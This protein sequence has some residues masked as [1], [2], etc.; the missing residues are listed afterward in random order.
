MRIATAVAR[1]RAASAPP[2]A[3]HRAR[4]NASRVSRA[5]RRRASTP[6]ASSTRFDLILPGDDAFERLRPR[7]DDED[8]D[9]DDDENEDEDDATAPRA[10]TV[11]RTGRALVARWRVDARFG[12]E[13]AARDALKLW[14]RAIG[15]EAGV[16]SDRFTVC[17]GYIGGREGALEL[18]VD[19]FGTLGEVEAFLSGVPREKHA[20]WGNAFAENIVDGTP[21]WVIMDVSGVGES[22]GGET[23]AAA[24]AAAAAAAPART[25]RKKYE[26]VDESELVPGTTLPDGRVVVEDWKGDPMVLNPG[27]RMPRF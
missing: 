4:A 7:D 27:D 9:D 5:R 23:G 24:A 3:A 26:D 16:S 1:A 14:A 17:S 21:E 8:D 18:R 6:A 13:A 22:A 15:A 11:G 10:P 20:A 2:R 12:R 19:G 25:P